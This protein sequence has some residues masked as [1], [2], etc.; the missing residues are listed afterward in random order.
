MRAGR[1][2][3]LAVDEAQNLDEKVLESVRVLSNFETPW[4]KLIQIVIAGQPQLAEMLARPSM[5]Q[6]R[7]RISSIIQLEHFTPQETNAYIDHRLW[8]A[9]YAGP[10]IFTVGARLLIAQHSGGIPRNINNLCFHS[11]ALASGL[12]KKQVDTMMVRE[13]IGDLSLDSS[14]SLPPPAP[15][16]P[17]DRESSAAVPFRAL[18]ANPRAA[19]A[20]VAASRRPGRLISATLVASTVLCLG[21]VSGASWKTDAGSFATATRPPQNAAGFPVTVPPSLPAPET[22]PSFET[23][24]AVD[25]PATTTAPDPS[26]ATAANA[27]PR[28]ISVT[29]EQNTTLRHLSLRYLDRF[30]SVTVAAIL[31]LNPEMTIRISYQRAS[32][33]VS[34][35]I[36]DSRCR[37]KPRK[38]AIPNERNQ[39]SPWRHSREPQL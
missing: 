30:D 38:A 35:Y 10:P 14:C 32:K 39:R 2:L 23:S 20:K 29:A 4:A 16:I 33:F 13:V 11:M 34:L 28:V 1:R 26:T 25:L 36:C 5:A 27:E 12:D 3:I 31:D 24:A 8:V 7:Q 22:N 19:P 37:R 21:L 15:G 6:L 9:G 18:M 17:S